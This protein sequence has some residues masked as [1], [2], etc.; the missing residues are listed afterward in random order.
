MHILGLLDPAGNSVYPCRMSNYRSNAR[1]EKVDQHYQAT[2]AVICGDV[3]IGKDVS[4]WFQTVAR[5]DVAPIKIGARTNIQEHCVLHCDTGKPLQIGEGVTIG[6]G[7]IVHC[8]KV[9]DRCLIGMKAV[10]LGDCVIGND[11]VIA[12]GAVLSPGTV[13]PDGMVA[14]G[15]PAKVV[16][17][18]KDAEREF[19]R[20]N[21]E[22][23]IELA[24]EQATHPQK[25]YR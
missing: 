23:Y 25:W 12:A 7:A 4:F 22:H 24:H 21:G 20:V 3:T 2:D 18:I 6:H 11:C 1:M 16:R 13:V 5:G 15:I 8:S 14:M 10:L 9:G 19:V 17:P